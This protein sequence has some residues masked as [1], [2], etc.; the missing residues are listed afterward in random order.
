MLDGL[1]AGQ[2]F[3]SVLERVTGLQPNE[4]EAAVENRLQIRYGWVAALASATSLFGLM[5]ILFVVGAFRARLR[6]RR[7]LRE[8]EA[9]E[10][11]FDVGPSS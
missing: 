10:A 6:T 8:M 5:T 9:E 1:A 4:F 7:R 2:S 11:L 3:G